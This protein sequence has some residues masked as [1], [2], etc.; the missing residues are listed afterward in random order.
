M[1]G[2]SDEGRGTKNHSYR[3]DVRSLRSLGRPFV[4]FGGSLGRKDEKNVQKEKLK[5]FI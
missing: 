4:A 5:L 1:A 3:E 2:R